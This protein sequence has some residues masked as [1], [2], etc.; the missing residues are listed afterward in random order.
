MKIFHRLDHK[1]I[2]IFFFFSGSPS[3]PSLH[4]NVARCNASIDLRACAALLAPGLCLGLFLLSM[5]VLGSSCFFFFFLSG[6]PP[7]GPVVLD[8]VGESLP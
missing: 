1:K 3:P 5:S 8:L 4:R 2:Q 7:A 6:C